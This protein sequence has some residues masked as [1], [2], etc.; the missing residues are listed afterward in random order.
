VQ[1]NVHSWSEEGFHFSP[2]P[3]QGGALLAMSA[4]N[5]EG[6]G[7]PGQRPQQSISASASPLPAEAEGGD[8]SP[9]EVDSEQEDVEAQPAVLAASSVPHG[10]VFNA[11]AAEVAGGAPGAASHVAHPAAFQ[12]PRPASVPP[13][14]VPPSTFAFTPPSLQS[15]ATRQRLANL[16]QQAAY[17]AAQARTAEAHTA[18]LE[19]ARQEKLERGE[20]PPAL[21]AELERIRQRCMFKMLQISHKNAEENVATPDQLEFWRRITSRFPLQDDLFL[22]PEEIALYARRAWE[23]RPF[24]DKLDPAV[25]GVEIVSEADVVKIEVGETQEGTGVRIAL[26]PS[27]SLSRLINGRLRQAAMQAASQS[28]RHT[29]EVD[30]PS[31]GSSFSTPYRAGSQP[32]PFVHQPPPFM[33]APPPQVQ[34]IGGF[35]AAEAQQQYAPSFGAPSIAQQPQAPASGYQP[36]AS[37]LRPPG[38]AYTTPQ[39]MGPAPAPPTTDPLL[40]W[41]YGLVP[42]SHQEQLRQHMAALPRTPEHQILDWTQYKISKTHFLPK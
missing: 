41:G 28:R 4:S 37:Q 25:V 36:P 6:S 1:R 14:S 12:P 15:A 3:Q 10:Q 17:V 2:P 11:G 42:P 18:R 33:P 31:H 13:Q 32:Q 29:P 34:T 21:P 23:A 7:A 35:T 19:A 40:Q 27:S 9:S 16:Q 24:L 30:L 26:G 20:E 22:Q 38:M 8:P 5:P 39:M